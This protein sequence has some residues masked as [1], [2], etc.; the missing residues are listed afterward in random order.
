VSQETTNH[1]FTISRNEFKDDMLN[2]VVPRQYN[3]VHVDS[4]DLAPDD[5][6][7]HPPWEEGDRR[8]HDASF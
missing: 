5:I 6:H 4:E 3:D 8:M 1:I 7:D 2:G